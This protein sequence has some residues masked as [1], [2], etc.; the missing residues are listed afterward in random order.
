MCVRGYVLWHGEATPQFV[1][2]EGLNY[3]KS[4]IYTHYVTMASMCV[5]E[6]VYVCVCVCVFYDTVKP[7]Y[8]F[9]YKVCIREKAIKYLY[10]YVG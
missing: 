5:C 9:A 7:H 1:V 8:F 2:V 6:C 4:N 3:M 10:K